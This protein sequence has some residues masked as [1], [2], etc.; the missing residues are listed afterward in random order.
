M[1]K[2]QTT[3]EEYEQKLKQVKAMEEFLRLRDGLP[4]LFGFKHYKWSREIFDSTNPEI[5]CTAANQLGK[6]FSAIRK[7]IALA[8]DP[9]LW[10]KFWPNLATNRHPSLFWYFLPTLANATTEVETKWL[11]FYLPQGEFKSDKQFGWKEEYFKGEIHAINFN[12]GVQIQFKSYTQKITDLQ[13][14]TVYHCTL[15]E[16]PPVDY[17]PEIRARLNATDGKLLTVFTATRGQEYFR[18][19]ME[20]IDKAD[21]LQPEALKIQVSLYD[22]QYYEDGTPSP[23]TDEKIKRAIAN[24]PTP[25]EVQRRVYGRF[26]KTEGLRYESFDMERNTCL[27]YKLEKEWKI[28][29]GVDIGSGGTSHP[30]AIV[31]IATSPDYKSAVV[32]RGWR[33][34]GVITASN[35][36]I[37]KYIE[38]KSDLMID[39]QVYDYSAK[40]FFTYA[41]RLGLAFRPADKS[42]ESGASLLNTLFKTGMLKIFRNDPELSK[43]IQELQSLP[44]KIDKSQ[45]KD[46]FLDALRYCV[47]QIPFDFSD[48]PIETLGE[49]KDLKIIREK[50]DTEKRRDWFLGREE[51]REPTIE[52]EFDEWGEMY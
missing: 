51:V 44:A 49:K 29:S 34:D 28:F 9:T 19:I 48:V 46:D 37:E 47:Q 33:G 43:L 11:P 20:P 36:V 40:D 10:P 45:A 25:I 2:K 18:R 15:D 8:T 17:L 14:A 32:F 52:D 50:S 23:W 24:C 26:V 42:R 5:Y 21:E 27:P 4:H 31:F 22:S 12:T 6:S 16:E 7:N 38:L 30:S 13:S 3:K 35:D 41:S 1:S 39:G